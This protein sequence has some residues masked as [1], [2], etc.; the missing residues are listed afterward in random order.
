MSKQTAQKRVD[1]IR[2]FREE[3]QQLDDEDVLR[4]T[5]EQS[6]RIAV[7]HEAL[8]ARFSDEFDIDTSEAQKRLSW[9][10]RIASF[11]GALALAAAV[12][13]FFYRFWGLLS[14][15]L[16]VLIVTAAPLMM[17]I[18]TELAARRERSGYFAGILGLL[19][20]GCFVLNI[21]VLGDVFNVTPSQKAFLP[22]A[23]FAFILAYGYGLRI[24]QMAGILSLAGYLS[25][26]CGTWG[27]AYWLSFG[28]RPENFFPA[29]VILVAIPLIRHRERH[30]FPPIYRV[31]G[32]LGLFIPILVLANWGSISYV[33]LEPSTVEAFYQ[34]LG[35]LIAGTAI[36]LG[37]RYRL[38]EV[39]NTGATFFVIYLYTKFFDWW[40]EWMPKYLFFMI[41]G[42]VAILLLI[43][44]KKMWQMGRQTQPHRVESSP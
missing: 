34:I 5:A 12:F 35:F 41:L 33:M 26:T 19:A 27:G 44:L 20:F 21:T 16:Q 37:I 7:H 3:L 13:L 2:A 22:W 10:M 43:L 23:A 30:D 4:L 17:L 9:G 18:G 25:A 11:L 28:E 39:T 42:L 36:W 6:D 29:A 8:L 32:L 1:R 24:L 40:W 14:T 31:F 15:T 38:G